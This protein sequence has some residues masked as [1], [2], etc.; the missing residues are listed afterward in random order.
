MP[1]DTSE[2]ELHDLTIYLREY[3]RRLSRLLPAVKSAQAF[4]EDVHDVEISLDEL[5]PLDIESALRPFCEAP[6][7]YARFQFQWA[8]RDLLEKLR[9]VADFNIGRQFPRGVYSFVRHATRVVGFALLSLERAT[10]D[11]TASPV[12]RRRNRA[13]TLRQR[14]PA[15][16][17]FL[18]TPPDVIE[19]IRAYRARLDDHMSPLGYSEAAPE[20]SLDPLP[21][22]L[23]PEWVL[24]H[25]KEAIEKALRTALGIARNRRIRRNL[26]VDLELL[27][28]YVPADAIP[29][30]TLEHIDKWKRVHASGG[31]HKART[32]AAK[33]ASRQ[34]H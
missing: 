19:I 29:S 12:P 23:Q 10:A 27:K 24:P 18:R 4:G 16:D 11:E 6:R 34:G 3:G 20:C 8:L 7:D 33:R 17:D 15:F 32:R 25:S 28:N 26:A 2:Q 1:P 13:A 14:V 9:A 22:L 31:R 5:L 30:N 21:C